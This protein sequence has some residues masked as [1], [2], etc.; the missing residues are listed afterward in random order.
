MKKTLLLGTTAL[1]AA[2]FAA[3]GVA[4]AEE[5]ISAGISGYYKAA[6]GAISQEN[7]DGELADANQSIALGQDTEIT[8]SGST[9]LDNGL[10]ASFNVNLEGNNGGQT[11]DEKWITLGGGFGTLQVGSI[12]SARQQMTKF[13]PSGNYNFGVNSEFFQ[14]ANVGPVFNIRTYSD[15]LGTE[16]SIKLVYFTPNFNGFR[17][18]ASFAPGSGENGTYGGNTTDVVGDLENHTA[19][20]MDFS[21]DLGG[22]T[23]SGMAAMEKYT[24]QTC[25]ASVGVN[26]CN[27]DPE[28]TQ[29][30]LVISMGEWSIGG[31]SL[32]SDQVTANTAGAQRDRQDADIGISYWSGMYGVGLQYGGAELDATDGSRDSAEIY[33]LNGTYVLGPGVDIGAA[34]TRVDA[35]DGSSRNDNSA[36]VFKTSLSLGF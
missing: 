25:N 13:A 23:I 7:G 16:D 2:G 9:T 28:S 20:G 32:W 21:R 19:L 27:D 29:V 5:P 33:E 24:L 3:S 35:E 15:G 8:I 17:I 31:G 12:E 1:V 36:T 34:F 22:F 14:F 26:T 4:Q 18:G 10:T 30:G 11:V 6:M